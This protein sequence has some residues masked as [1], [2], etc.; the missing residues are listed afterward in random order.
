MKSKS[1]K[2]SKKIVDSGNITSILTEARYFKPPAEFSKNAH[3]KSMAQYKRLYQ[4]SVKTP[5]KFW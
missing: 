1:K 4:Q 5:E 3:I 2:S